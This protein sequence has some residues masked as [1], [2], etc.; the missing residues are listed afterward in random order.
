MT[1]LCSLEKAREIAEQHGWLTRVSPGFRSEVLAA[2][3]L[4]RLAPGDTLYRAGDESSGIFGLISGTL[5]VSVMPGAQGAY[6]AH[7]LQPGSWFGELPFISGQPRIVGISAANQS[8]VLHLPKRALDGFIRKDLEV[9]RWIAVLANDNFQVAVGVSSDLMIRDS[10]RR[11]IAVL[12]R[13]GGYSAATSDL[14]TPREIPVSQDD[15]AAMANLGRT[16]VSELL[17]ELAASRQIELTYRCVTI[18]AARRLRSLVH[19]R[20]V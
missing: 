4:V 16:K 8:Y 1:V 9:W 5:Q 10:K 14:D 3:Q 17:N 6:F 15:L 20:A 11:L 2:S 19:P 7:F 13:L 12:L 18:L